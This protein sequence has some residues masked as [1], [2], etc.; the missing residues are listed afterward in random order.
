MVSTSVRRL[1]LIFLILII[2]FFL[3]FSTVIRATNQLPSELD[4][5]WNLIDIRSRD[6]VYATAYLRP[7]DID[8]DTWRSNYFAPNQN[9]YYQGMLNRLGGMFNLNAGTLI[10]YGINDAEK[11]VYVTIRFS[12]SNAGTYDQNTDCLKIIDVLKRQGTGYFD[13]LT[14]KSSL[15]IFNVDPQPVR[16][17]DYI[18]YWK[19]TDFGSAP[20]LYTICF[21]RTMTIRVTVTGLPS[22]IKVSIYAG[23][24]KL[25]D[26]VSG[27]QATF[28]LKEG[29]YA[30]R[31]EPTTYDISGQV[32]YMLKNPTITVSSS[33]NV[34]FEYVKE[35]QVFIQQSAGFSR[36]R[37][38]GNWY[39][40]P[41]Q[42][43]LVAG[44]H[45]LY[46]EP[47]VT[48]Q[49]SSD[50]R[51]VYKFS[52]WLVGAAAYYSNPQTIQI[53]DPV[54]VTA[55]YTTRK[56]YRVSI[57]TRYSSPVEGF[58]GESE[59][60]R[61]SEPPEKVEGDVKYVFLGW[62]SQGGLYTKS[63]ELTVTVSGPILLESRWDK[64]YKV[65]VSC[66]PSAACKA[67][68]Y[69]YKEGST[70][71]PATYRV[72][73]IVYSGSDTRYVFQG[74]STGTQIVSSPSIVYK[75]YKTQYRVSVEPGEGRAFI[76]EGEWV[77]EGSTATVRVESTRFGFPVQTVL[78]GFTAEGGSIEALDTTQGWARVK[79]NAPTIVYV[80]WGKDYTLLYALLAVIA[81]VTVVSVVFLVRGGLQAPIGR[82][83]ATLRRDEWAKHP[84][85]Q[86]VATAPQ[87]GTRVVSLEYLEGELARLVEEAKRYRDYLEKLEVAKAEGKVAETA[88]GELKKEYTEK[89]AKLEREIRELQEA[90][91][92][93]EEQK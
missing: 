68:E 19:N 90:K 44:Q 86:P 17:D 39:Y 55:E 42:L 77:D 18:A 57:R 48:L 59:V 82:V 70:F 74:W 64:Y 72:E 83:L 26:I 67:E 29:T 36:V 92:R 2:V 4:Y 31:L 60:L 91:K 51:T 20:S 8:W 52:R 78:T 65:T 88:Y 41:A 14:V 6:E 58:Y 71:D 46:A 62:Y 16:K 61:V 50:S 28:Q 49:S 10:A 34:T 12:L 89:L 87:A 27:S 66:K 54:T 53:S 40:L 45:E 76:E 69:W 93:L 13:A 15:K 80:R 24:S 5:V 47:T 7:A 35:V 84:T 75:L 3:D 38:N 85:V 73:D 32:R 22:N 30:L 25:G 9:S 11:Y 23:S 43:W 1:T 79:V 37:I 21:S 81:V 33:S 63:N 56:E